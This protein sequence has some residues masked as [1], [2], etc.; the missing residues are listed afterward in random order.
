MIFTATATQT[1]LISFLEVRS[2]RESKRSVNDNKDNNYTVGLRGRLLGEACRV[3]WSEQIKASCTKNTDFFCAADML[4]HHLLVPSVVGLWRM[5]RHFI[6]LGMTYCTFT[7]STNH[8]VLPR[9]CRTK[10]NEYHIISII[11]WR[12]WDIEIFS[13]FI[14]ATNLIV[15][16]PYVGF[17]VRAT[18]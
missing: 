16:S 15:C 10:K 2:G 6:W 1:L 5:L 7:P 17:D 8:T 3:E 4:S 14:R 18:N 13:L 11:Q 9:G 12:M